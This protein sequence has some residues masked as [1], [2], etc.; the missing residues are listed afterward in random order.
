MEWRIDK[1]IHQRHEI[2]MLISGWNLG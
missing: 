1:R 2:F